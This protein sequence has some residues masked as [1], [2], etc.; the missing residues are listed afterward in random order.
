MLSVLDIFR[1]K[2]GVQ[3]NE[4]EYVAAAQSFMLEQAPKRGR[5]CLCLQVG[6]NILNKLLN[7]PACISSTQSSLQKLQDSELPGHRQGALR[8]RIFFP[9]IFSVSPAGCV[10]GHSKGQ[11]ASAGPGLWGEERSTLVLTH[12]WGLSPT[13]LWIFT[14]AKRSCAGAGLSAPSHPDTSLRTSTHASKQTRYS[15]RMVVYMKH[16]YSLCYCRVESM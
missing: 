5:L 11:A 15:K 2:D 1:K 9:Y 6:K 10:H 14:A 7:Y 13:S 16:L 12:G 4:T 3:S 8:P